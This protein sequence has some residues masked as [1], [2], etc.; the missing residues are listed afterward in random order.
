MAQVSKESDCN[1]ETWVRSLSW[2]DPLE[3]V[4]ATHTSILCL[5]N[6]MDK[7]TSK[8]QSIWSQRVGHD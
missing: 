8:L 1:A 4:M 3:T 7:G 2:E 5:E 6:P